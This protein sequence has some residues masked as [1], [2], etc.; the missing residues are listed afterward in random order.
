MSM[1]TVLSVAMRPATTVRALARS[2]S[3]SLTPKD[4][5]LEKAVTPTLERN[6]VEADILSGAPPEIARHTARIY[7][8]AKS[9]T[10]S[11]TAGTH[12]WKLDFDTKA[13]WENPLMGWS[14]SADPVQALMI[15]FDTKEDAIG[16]AK[17]QGYDYWVEEPKSSHSR[18]KV[19]AEN[20]T[21]SRECQSTAVFM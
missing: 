15:K 16:F 10:Q 1:R 14:S 4:S 9:A 6:L 18:V 12:Y 17:R 11:G 5:V 19:Y 2:M 21:V 20:F 8:P 7:Q 3:S 13:R